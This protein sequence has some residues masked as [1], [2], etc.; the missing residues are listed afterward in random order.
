MI[1]RIDKKRLLIL[2]FGTLILLAVFLSIFFFSETEKSGFYPENGIID[3]KN[4][5]P[6]QS[7]MLNLSGEWLF[8]WNRFVSYEEYLAGA[9]TPDISVYVPDVWNSYSIKG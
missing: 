4:W 7:G 3:L 6:E 2:V 5:Q 8:Y 1:E 9:Y